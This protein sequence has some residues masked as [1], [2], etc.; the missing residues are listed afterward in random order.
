MKN[1]GN[2]IEATTCVT[3]LV[4]NTDNKEIMVKLKN[5]KMLINDDTM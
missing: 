2:R 3:E 1:K 4:N 5:G